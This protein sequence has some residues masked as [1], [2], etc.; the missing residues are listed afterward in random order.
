MSPE[1]TEPPAGAAQGFC[2]DLIEADETRAGVKRLEAETAF[3]DG[4]PAQSVDFDWARLDP[5]VDED[6]AIKLTPTDRQETVAAVLF[7]VFREDCTSL[8]AADR[9][10]VRWMCFCW[11]TAPSIFRS[12][13]MNDLAGLT[14]RN[15][16]TI[17]RIVNALAQEFGLPV[18]D[19]KPDAQRAAMSIGQ[20]R[21]AARA[22]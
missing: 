4:L 18:P 21:A 14:N 16:S 13:S 3:A 7:A 20:I 9:A 8:A 5:S 15:P 10:F 1:N 17:C 11:L 22:A 12:C 6:H 2:N 19:A